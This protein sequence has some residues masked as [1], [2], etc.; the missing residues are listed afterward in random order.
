MAEPLASDSGDE[1]HIKKAIKE[2]KQLREEKRKS[3]AVK[4][5][6]EKS[7]QQDERSRSIVQ[8]KPCSRLFDEKVF[9]QPVTWLAAS[10]F[11]SV[12]LQLQVK[13]HNG[14]VPLTMFCIF[15][16]QPC[17]PKGLLITS[18]VIT[19]AVLAIWCWQLNVSCCYDILPL[20]AVLAKGVI[21]AM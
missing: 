19:T 9:Q 21:Q 11:S 15:T 20:P 7:V 1:K 17:W 2:T 6:A 3:V 18:T 14:P 16:T 13:H 8:E 12:E 5:K 4:W 10:L